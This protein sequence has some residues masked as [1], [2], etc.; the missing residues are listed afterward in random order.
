MP[1]HLTPA[2]FQALVRGA[3]EELPSSFRPYLQGLEVRVEDYPEDELMREWGL[4]PPDYPFGMY[5][6]P[7][8][9]EA[10][11]P[12]DFEGTLVIY[13]RPLEEWC[14]TPEELRDQIR[15][16]V[17]HELAH[18]LGFPDEGMLDELR[19]GVGAREVEVDW[20]EAR[21]YL[22]QAEHDLSVAELLLGQRVYDWA[23]A[24]ALTACDRA[25]RAWL[26][27]QGEDPSVLEGEG[28]S[29]LLARAVRRSP[30]FRR[31]KTLLR[32]ENV[33]LHMGDRAALAPRE[34]IR[35]SRAREALELAQ[36]LVQLARQTVPGAA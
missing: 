10:E 32:M 9:L 12:R 3:L 26:V 34:R 14:Q 30:G 18:R 8:I 36:G 24:A 20:E 15:R 22:E 33:S 13:K 31:F 17:Y 16:T 35:P 6:G 5:E 27:V 7:S 21:R 29:D 23:F 2:A 28:I 4:V 25:L 1:V 19:A 11:N